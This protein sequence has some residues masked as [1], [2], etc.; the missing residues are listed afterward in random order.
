M[1]AARNKSLAAMLGSLLILAGCGGGGGS[2]AANGNLGNSA[3]LAYADP[4]HYSSAADASLAAA[5]EQA[6]QMHGQLTLNGQ[7]IRYTATSGHLTA[8]DPRNG[9]PEASF[10]Y[11]AYTA[12][13]QDAAKRPLTF[14]YNGGPGSATIWLHMGSYGPKRIA[15]NAPATVLSSPVQFIDNAES[16]LDTSDLVFVDAVGTGYSQAIAPNTNQSFWG[17]DQD[18]AVFR[19][20]VMRYVSVNLRAAS[21]KFL[22]GES[23]GAPR[24]A[25]LANLLEVAGLRLNGLVLQSSILNYNS[26]CGV[27]NPG[28]VSC[29]GFV[30]SYAAIGAYY[31]LSNPVPTDL[32]A[33]LL[34]IRAFSAASYRPAVTAYITSKTAPTADLVTQMVNYTGLAAGYWQQNFN[35]DPGTFQFSL[36]PGRLMGRYDA[37][38]YANFGTALASEGDPSS[39]LISGAF[40]STLSGYLANQLKYTANSSYTVSANAVASWDFRHDG[41]S[42]P[43]TLPDLA[44]ALALNPALKVM[45]L[46][47]Y[48]DLATPFYQTELD[49]ARLGSNANIQVRNYSGGHMNYLDDASRRLAKAEL[50]NFYAAA[51]AAH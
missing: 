41:L 45:A 25:V 42:V 7:A 10:F 6:A 34:Q 9:L 22:F 12:D 30:P 1:A 37:R 33:Y 47:G 26:N 31:N 32:A 28:A 21:P 14:F 38:I 19:D 43:D 3:D 40:A 44:A 20:F 4:T 29:E 46:N 11:V 36:L 48:H 23:Y 27:F 5:N 50:V 35:L 8:S 15:T 39:T 17:V 2:P 13:S 49:L 16:L 18:A 24:T 51:V